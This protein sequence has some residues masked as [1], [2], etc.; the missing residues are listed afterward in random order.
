M[1]KKA[2]GKI[3]PGPSWLVFKIEVVGFNEQIINMIK[4]GTDYIKLSQLRFDED[5][6]LRNIPEIV[7][8]RLGSL[9]WI[10]K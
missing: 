9:N 4:V 1:A 8:I 6:N 2:G 7:K 10:F 3:W 5:I